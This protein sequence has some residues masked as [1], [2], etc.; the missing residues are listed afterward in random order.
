MVGCRIVKLKHDERKF[1]F[2]ITHES[3]KP[4]KIAAEDEDSF[5]WWTKTLA[6]AAIGALGKSTI[7][8]DPYYEILGLDK[9]EK[10][11]STLLSRAFRKKG[12]TMHPDKEGGS[13]ESFRKVQ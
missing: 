10:L 13:E 7:D 5:N 1:T 6:R 8:F 12:I 3:R 9:N 4:V 2:A 11:T